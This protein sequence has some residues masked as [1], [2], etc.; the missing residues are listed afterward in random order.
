MRTEAGRRVGRS[1]GRR[2]K[3][4]RAR[5][6]KRQKCARRRVWL[7][8]WGLRAAAWW[9]RARR[10][11]GRRQGAAARTGRAAWTRWAARRRG[12][13]AA[14]PRLY[15]PPARSARRAWTARQH[16]ELSAHFTFTRNY[17]LGQSEQWSWSWSCRPVSQTHLANRLDARAARLHRRLE[18]PACST[19]T[20]HVTPVAL[21]TR[22]V[23]KVG[24]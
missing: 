17:S 11:A 14:W 8:S 12:T 1:D 19:S 9:A 24:H 5:H 15:S 20:V 6:W 23:T 18:V 22:L 3:G 7:R 4:S 13:R 21:D 10:C 2:W 16:T